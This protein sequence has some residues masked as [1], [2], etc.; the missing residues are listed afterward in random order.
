[1]HPVGP[2]LADADHGTVREFHGMVVPMIHGDTLAELAA[3][4]ALAGALGAIVGIGGGV[5]LVPVLTLLF[6]VSPH[7]AVATSL[8]GVVAT[9]TAAGSVYV[10]SGVANMRLGMA[11]EVATTVGG[12]LGGLAAARVSEKALSSVFAVLLVVVAILL[13]LG[14][15]AEHAA[16]RDGQRRGSSPMG[17]EEHG[18]L[19]GAYYDERE[20]RLVPYQARRWPLGASISLLAGFV[21]GLLGVGGGFLKV[22]AMAVGMRVPIRVAA[23]TSNFMIGV[24]AIASLFIYFQ[25]GFLEPVLAAPAAV[26]VVAGSLA[27]T[28]IAG[29]LPT[30]VLRLLTAAVLLFVAVQ[31]ILHF[32]HPPATGHGA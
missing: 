10:G 20:R 21:S 23:A 1:M 15:D 22:P 27:A 12:M 6:H 7:V 2:A 3:L 29:K 13:A 11:L 18:R 28:R 30:R 14:R 25:R 5:L 16:S 31:M 8:V 26:G 19:A 32:T 24:T 9:S 4:G 17:W